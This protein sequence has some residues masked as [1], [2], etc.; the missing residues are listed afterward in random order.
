MKRILFF[1]FAAMMAL[2][3]NAQGIDGS[4]VGKLNVGSMSLNVVFNFTKGADGKL[5]CT[6]DSPDQG[7]KNIPAEVVS[8]DLA[9]LKV[10]V[11]MIGATYEGALVDDEIK[12]TFAQNGF[13]FP[14]NLKRGKVEMKR[15]QEP[16][17]PF[18]YTTEEVSFSNDKAN[19]V[20]AGTLTYPVGYDSKSSVPVVIMV[21]GSGLQDRDESLF[22]HKPFL[23]I[24][25]HLARHGIASLRYDDR[26]FA[27]STGDVSQATT[28]D[29]MQDAAAG[30]AWLRSQGKKF[31]NVGVI[32]HSEGSTIAFMLAAKGKVDF[33]ISFAGPGAKGDTILAGQMNAQLEQ[34]GSSKRVTASDV[35]KQIAATGRA[36]EKYFIDYDPQT[37]IS[38]VH[39]PV[40]AVNGSKD[41]QVTPE[42]NFSAIER[43][44]PN[45]PKNLLKRYDGLNHLLQHCTTGYPNEYGQI[46]ETISPE[47]LSDMAEWINKFFQKND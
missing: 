40:M 6:M 35:R 11:T 43:L 4:W 20:L 22:G 25:D 28:A 36:W 30:V 37:D 3:I 42:L 10:A 18:P 13:S 27:K 14:L 47:V 12:G 26:G 45:N 33:I 24:A 44:L 31:S 29:F 7:A 32:G 38:A 19:A 46:K 17:A 9:K 21:S 5:A 39:C 1:L 41:F 23:V 34:S 2:T 15:P 8:G 16:K